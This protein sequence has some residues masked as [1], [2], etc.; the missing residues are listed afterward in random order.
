MRSSYLS[1][2]SATLI[3][4]AA[5]QSVIIASPAVPA[6]EI[7]YNALGNMVWDATSDGLQ[8]AMD[9]LPSL[10]RPDFSGLRVKEMEHAFITK[11]AE[12]EE[13]AAGMLESMHDLL[14]DGFKLLE[15]KAN[16]FL[17]RGKVLVDGIEYDKLVHPFFPDYALRITS[18]PGLRGVPSHMRESIASKASFCDPDVYSVSGYLDISETKHL[19]FIFFESRNNP[20]KDPLVLWLNGGPGCSSS[21]GLLFELGP[22]SIADER[23]T[24]NNPHSWTNKA[25]MIFLDQPASGVGY[26][27]SEEGTINNTP[28]A[29]VDIYA[30][31]QLFMQKFPKYASLPFH[32]AAESYGG[33][34]LPNF[35][36]YIWK[37]N[38]AL[39][40]V[41]AS[42]SAHKATKHAVA[43]QHINLTSVLIGNGLSAPAI[44]FPSVVDFA[45][46]KDNEY[47]MF[48]PES[49]QC[50]AMTSKAKTCRSLI[51]SC[52]KYNNSFTCTPAAL[53]CWS[54]MYSPMQQ[55]GLNLYDVRR[56][57]DRD[58]SKDGPLCYKQ[59]EY[60][61][62]LM[63]KPEI[64]K[65]LGVPSKVDFQSCNMQVNQAFLLH[66]DSMHDAASLLIPLIEDDIRVLI[67][68]GETDAMCNWIGNYQ[69]VQA[70]DTSY[71]SEFA[72]APEAEWLVNGKNAGFVRTATGSSSSSKTFGN[73]A[74]L[75][76]A[77]AGHM[78]PYDQP[79]AAA[80]MFE[81][82]LANEALDT[83]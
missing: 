77:K 80:D 14:S 63:N 7:R 39:R 9:E 47:R 25:N 28:A 48:D 33:M 18:Q 46:G 20:K 59:M 41:A 43:P 11:L 19:W 70:L 73:L 38:Q 37:Q 1:T 66:G 52:Y 75:K 53:Y 26:S 27:Y 6:E 67:Y 60:I 4:A 82:W 56:S 42:A 54:G 45:C 62:T 55:S 65:Q 23:S 68:A 72:A 17:H 83:M 15:D 79:E 58:P 34:Y 24:K 13:D 21:T 71:A 81:K 30:F 12:V 74:F 10:G 32:M 50:V 2:V 29:A 44:Q 69:W 49:S 16:S 31:L 36:N 5:L 22:C 35:S 61:Q 57:C 76:V 51:E 3:C 40:S 64:K 78:V 8:Q